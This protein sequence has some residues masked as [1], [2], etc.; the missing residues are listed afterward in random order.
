[1]V[2][3]DRILSVSNDALGLRIPAARGANLRARGVWF[4]T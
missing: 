4:K 1:M 3:D 2:Q